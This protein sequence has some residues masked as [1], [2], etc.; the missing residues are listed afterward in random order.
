MGTFLISLRSIN[1][2]TLIRLFN[3]S[4]DVVIVGPL[5]LYTQNML[6]LAIICPLSA[7]IPRSPIF[8]GMYRS[9]ASSELM[10]TQYRLSFSTFSSSLFCAL[11][12][13][14]SPLSSYL[15]STSRSKCSPFNDNISCSKIS[16]FSIFVAF[17]QKV[18]YISIHL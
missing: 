9:N 17:R 16:A 6:F 14:I 13:S 4:H 18:L 12:R 11:F 10:I 3:F 5:R 2:S 15:W 1:S 8:I 7:I